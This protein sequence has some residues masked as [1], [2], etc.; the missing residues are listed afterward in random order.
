MEALLVLGEKVCMRSGTHAMNDF[1]IPELLGPADQC[2]HQ[3]R[4][5][6]E[7]VSEDD[8]ISGLYMGD[9]LLRRHDLIFV[10][11]SPA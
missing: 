10:D 2:L 5:L 6:A 11:F 4:R 7:P 1:H 3:G 8:L 9:H